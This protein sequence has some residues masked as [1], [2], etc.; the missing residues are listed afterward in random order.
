MELELVEEEDVKKYKKT[1]Q[2]T[3]FKKYDA[4]IEKHMEWLKEKIKNSKDGRIII[5]TKQ[6]AKSLGSEFMGYANQTIFL[7][8]KLSLWKKDI[9]VEAGKHKKDDEDLLILRTKDE[10][11]TLPSKLKRELEEE[12]KAAEEDEKLE[13]EDETRAESDN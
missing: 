7:S 6:F 13:E 12:E 10:Y 5:R 8:V 2:K 1:R 4:A 3:R 11:D 9:F